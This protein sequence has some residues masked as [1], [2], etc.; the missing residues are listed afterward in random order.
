[1][2][3]EIIRSGKDMLKLEFC[4]EKKYELVDKCRIYNPSPQVATCLEYKNTATELWQC[5]ENYYKN[6]QKAQQEDIIKYKIIYYLIGLSLEMYFKAFLLWAEDTLEGYKSKKN[7]LRRKDMRHNLTRLYDEAKQKG[8]S[9]LSKEDQ[10]LI[11]ELDR[12]YA[13]SSFR[14]KRGININGV[15]ITNLIGIKL[16]APHYYLTIAKKI[17]VKANNKIFAR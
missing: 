3:G 17:R 13:E 5:I 7:S 1:M 2:K 12:Y 11:Y 4:E 16:P 14:Y 6:I 15:E 9:F 8:L 10:K